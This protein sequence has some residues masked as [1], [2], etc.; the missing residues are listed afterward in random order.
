M[1]TLF[2]CE[3]RSLVASRKKHVRRRI[4][5]LVVDAVHHSKKHSGPTTQEP[6]QTAAELR[7]LDLTAVARAYGT[8]G[9]GIK[10]AGLEEVHFS[11]EFEAVHVEEGFGQA[12]LSEDVAFEKPLIG[13][14][15]N[16]EKR[17]RP[18][19][20]R[21]MGPDGL[22]VRQG[23]GRLPI[24]AVQDVG[25]KSEPLEGFEGGHG[26]ETEP[27]AVIRI[28]LGRGSIKEIPI[29]IFVLLNK[30]GDDAVSGMRFHGKSLLP[31]SDIHFDIVQDGR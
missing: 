19:E 29:E 5:G 16:G 13:Q 31:A 30:I 28:I 24:V 14:I 21:I 20:K 4:P 2:P 10:D 22:E 3:V 11:P 8:D 17:P 15:V 6:V 1:Q 9:R 12:D 27:F 25:G 7:R 26:K 23:D 18:R